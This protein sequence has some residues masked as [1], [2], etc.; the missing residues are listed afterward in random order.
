MLKT[1]NITNLNL[2]FIHVFLLKSFTFSIISYHIYQQ[3]YI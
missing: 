3:N 2:V 1:I